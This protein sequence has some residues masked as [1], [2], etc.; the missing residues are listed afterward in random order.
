MHILTII[1]AHTELTRPSPLLLTHP[2]SQ[3]SDLPLTMDPSSL[4]AT[5]TNITGGNGTAFPMVL[6]FAW[7]PHYYFT[8]F[9]ATVVIQLTCFFIAYACQ[10]SRKGRLLNRS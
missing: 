1:H 4:L 6:P 10:V 2:G 5:A 9:L 7:D 3:V 8:S